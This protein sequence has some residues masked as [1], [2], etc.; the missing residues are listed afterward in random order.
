MKQ[1]MALVLGVAIAGAAVGTTFAQGTG[2]GTVY[3]G[4]KCLVKSSSSDMGLLF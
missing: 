1:V 3:F 2:S 4:L